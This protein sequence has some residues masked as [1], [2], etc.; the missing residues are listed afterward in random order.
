[1]LSSRKFNLVISDI[2]LGDGTGIELYDACGPSG[3]PFLFMTGNVMDA[4]LMKYFEDNKLP[5]LK[6]P[7]DLEDLFSEIARILSAATV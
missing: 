2:V 5:Y 7:F 6:K 3:P 4:P 1:M